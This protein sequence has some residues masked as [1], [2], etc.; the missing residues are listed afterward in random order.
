MASLNLSDYVILLVDDNVELLD[1]LKDSIEDHGYQVV[2]AD[3][4]SDALD[5]IQRYSK[6]LILI[7]SD[8]Q[9]PEMDGFEFREKIEQ[10]YRDIP[11]V[12]LSAFITKDMALTGIDKQICGFLNKPVAP[13]ELF[14]FIK[15]QTKVRIE[16]IEFSEEVRGVFLQEA[17]ELIEEVEPLLLEL[18]KNPDDSDV[19]NGIYRLIHT[20]K[21]GSNVL[22]CPSV[23]KFIHSYEDICS[24]I[25]NGEI[26]SSPEVVS[27]LLS[28][29]DK[30][31]EIISV[32]SNDVDATFDLD[33]LLKSIEIN[34]EE[35]TVQK[36]PAS[37]ETRS[38]NPETKALP[39][40]KD[41]FSVPRNLMD[42]FM[43][44]SGEITVIRN[45][46]NK[47]VISIS[48]EVPRSKNVQ[49]LAELLDEMHKVNS[50]IQKKITDIR[51][52]S[53]SSVLRPI[54]RVVRD[55]CNAMGKKIKVEISGDSLRV[56]HII[57]QALS[58]SLVHLVRNAV[59]HGIET[60][61]VRLQANKDP[62]GTLK[63][64]CHEDN[65]NIVVV[66]E[67]DGNGIDP[68]VI[69]RKAVEKGVIPSEE[70]EALSDKKIISMIFE[71]GFSTAEQIT[72]ISG[73]G[74]GMDMVRS[75]VAILGGK[76]DIDSTL[77]AGTRFELIMPI[78]K[79]I[80]IIDSLIIEVTGN[81]FAVPQDNIIR[82]MT[83]NSQRDDKPL[84]YA[85]GAELLSVDDMIVP[86]INTRKLLGLSVDIVDRDFD[87]NFIIIKDESEIHYALEVDKIID[88]ESIVVKA[89]ED[90]LMSIGPYLGATFLGDGAVGLILDTN[91][92]LKLAEVSD[93]ESQKAETLT[94]DESVLRLTTPY[95][96]FQ[97]STDGAFA[98]P[99][100]EIF[101]LEQF[102]VAEVYAVSGIKIIKYRGKMMQIFDLC[103]AIG[104]ERA[105]ES[106]DRVDQQVVYTLVVEKNGT[107]IGFVIDRI[108]DIYYPANSVNQSY[109]D[110]ATIK[111]SLKLNDHLHMVLN[112]DKIMDLV[113]TINNVELDQNESS[114]NIKIASA[115]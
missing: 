77:G 48:K 66:I 85:G 19:V 112:I 25:K 58:N 49:Q 1:V 80:Q 38:E 59:D 21:G 110:R 82:L 75:S 115:S 69:R 102:H 54:P 40:K 61:E 13:D 42:E 37:I 91:G 32:F 86:V 26:V 68:Q 23:T 5:A 41:S 29:F 94:D 18:E 24:K 107:Y 79:S 97:L 14:D 98:V 47:L 76:I 114:Q 12:I 57:S 81:T 106:E 10:K 27:V 64:I 89:I 72:D 4:G 84:W 28:G 2:T 113:T 52:V 60:P 56:D 45:M 87:R 74:V 109:T 55:A 83:I 7:I 36:E 33:D 103:E 16:E 88:N 63:V 93:I 30:V 22:D 65:E 43:T 39:Q 34:A 51:K 101:R 95:I 31:C 111:G 70:A 99:L 8:Y 100:H 20:I 90:G 15:V 44:Q 96:S 46:V 9:M 50:S 3:N 67:D 73:R 108:L 92:L 78:P 62:T 53:I 71:P 105:Q 35:P 6:N 11:F 17:A 104:L